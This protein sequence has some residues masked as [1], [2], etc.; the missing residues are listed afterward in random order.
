MLPLKK[1]ENLKASIYKDSRK[2]R[3]LTFSTLF[4]YIITDVAFIRDAYTGRC[5][6]YS[7][8]FNLYYNYKVLAV[9]IS[10]N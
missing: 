2:A 9:K 10:S 4:L 1:Y 7:L 3:Y 5:L 6:F 8:N